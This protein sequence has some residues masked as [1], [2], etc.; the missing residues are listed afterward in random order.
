[1]KIEPAELAARV[2]PAVSLSPVDLEETGITVHQRRALVSSG[3]LIRARRG[4]YVRA[5]VHE[6][7]LAAARLGARLDCV[8]LLAA[9]GVYVLTDEVLHVQCEQGASRLPPRGQDVVA[10]WRH[11]A[12][13]PATLAADLVQALAQAVRCQSIRDALATLDSAWHHGLVGETDIAAVF[14]Q[15]PRRYRRLRGL[16]DRRAESGPETIMRL[17]FRALGCDVQVQVKL[18]GV[19]RVD[20]IIDG[21][22]IVECDSKAHHEGWRS[23]LE[24]RRRDIAA[25]ALGYTTVR[26]IAEDILY[27][28]ES[29]AEAMKRVLAHGPRAGHVPN[30]SNR[31]PK[32]ATRRRSRGVRTESEELGT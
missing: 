3:R 5:D 1:M 18:P 27:R 25:A 23:Q 10:H 9:L 17:L 6:K 15:L 13:P 31:G 12:Q 24:D 29:V 28:R 20:L 19:G 11:S 32:T 22:L 14:A 4:Q 2:L 21:W 8:S 16:L 7:L 26:P 30:S